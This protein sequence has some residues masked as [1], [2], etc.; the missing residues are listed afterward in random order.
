LEDGKQE[1]KS[2]SRPVRQRKPKING[3]THD[4]IMFVLRFMPKTV[5]VTTVM[6]LLARALG[7]PYEAGLALTLFGASISFV[8]E[9]GWLP[10][11]LSRLKSPQRYWLIQHQFAMAA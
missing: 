1:G 11:I 7:L 8:F 2:P 4:I 9:Q 10:P 6:S 3:G 5:G